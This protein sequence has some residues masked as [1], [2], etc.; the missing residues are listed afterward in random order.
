[1]NE[2][3]NIHQDL[4]DISTN[5]NYYKDMNLN[6]EEF[7]Q[8]ELINDKEDSLFLANIK[9]INDRFDVEKLRTMHQNKIRLSDNVSQLIKLE[10][11]NYN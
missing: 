9:N 4:Q 10:V 2:K 1:M 5:N 11:N 8:N 7:R 3:L 6:E